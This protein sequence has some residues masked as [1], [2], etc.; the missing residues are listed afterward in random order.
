M[1]GGGIR[2]LKLGPKEARIDVFGCPL[3]KSQ[4]FRGACRGLVQNLIELVCQ[5]AYAHEHPIGDP[6]TSLSLRMQWV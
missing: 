5:K 3:F 6:E 1:D 2:V 4:Y